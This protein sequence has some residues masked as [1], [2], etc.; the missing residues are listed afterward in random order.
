MYAAAPAEQ[1]GT[2][3]GLYRTSQYI[4]A[5]LA[6]ALVGLGLGDH[7][8]DSGL[9]VLAMVISV[10]SLLLLVA[11]VVPLCRKKA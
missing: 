9:H 8:T 10:I 5:N 7:A 1:V 11:A 3:S 6:A 4:G 2:A